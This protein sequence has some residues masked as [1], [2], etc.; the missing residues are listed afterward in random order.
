MSDPNDMIARRETFRPPFLHP[1]D[2]FETL[3]LAGRSGTAYDLDD[4]Q[5]HEILEAV[6]TKHQIKTSQWSLRHTDPFGTGPAMRALRDALC[7]SPHWS[8]PTADVGRL[9][10]PVEILFTILSHVDIATALT[11]AQV[12]R[13]ARQILAGSMTQY[14]AI[15]THA[16]HV[17][18]TITRLRVTPYLTFSD[19][20]ALLLNDACANCGDNG[21][22][23]YLPT[24]ERA[25]EICIDKDPWY[26]VIR[27]GPKQL[28]QIHEREVPPF[29]LIY[30]QAPRQTN[31]FR[32]VDI[33]G[34][35]WI[36]AVRNYPEWF[37]STEK[38][39]FMPVKMAC[40]NLPAV[41]KGGG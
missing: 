37:E 10:F 27:L 20:N 2:E 15:T 34:Y 33:P 41:Y 13:R 17:V 19:L 11:F 28:K 21:R 18:H 8:P 4:N 26:K 3:P 7:G 5:K 38:V 22:L 39:G 35:H 24:L 25:C 36:M 30:S 32:A 1:I 9:A 6:T 40:V 23:L 12:N 14:P 31:F 29:P 16:L